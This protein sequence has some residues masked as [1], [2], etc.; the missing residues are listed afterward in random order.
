LFSATRGANFGVICADR[1]SKHILQDFDRTH[2]LL[3]TPAGNLGINL[4]KII[5]WGQPTGQ[6]WNEIADDLYLNRSDLTRHCGWV[7]FNPEDEARNDTGRN[8]SGSSDEIDHDEIQSFDA[9]QPG[10]DNNNSNWVQIIH[11]QIENQQD[12][13]GTAYVKV[14][15]HNVGFTVWFYS[16]PDG[17]LRLKIMDPVSDPDMN[18]FELLN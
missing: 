8:I 15:L 2:T 7:Y 3:R 17:R 5:K 4:E 14:A 18:V 9:R 16:G 11:K 12:P 1:A 10:P 13:S 6:K